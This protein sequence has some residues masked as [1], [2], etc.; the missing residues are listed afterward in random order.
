[1]R[2]SPSDTLEDRQL[3][4]LGLILCFAALVLFLVSLVWI[5]STTMTVRRSR[6]SWWALGMLILSLVLCTVGVFVLLA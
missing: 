2:R 5:Y 4:A 3:T 6:V 1:V